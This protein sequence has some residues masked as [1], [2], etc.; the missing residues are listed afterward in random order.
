MRRA[1]RLILAGL[2]VGLG[3]CLADPV[4][5]PM[6]LNTPL[7]SYSTPA[8]SR[9]SGT[10]IAPVENGG[11]V[12]LPAGTV[13]H[14]TVRR[15]AKVGVGLV[16]DRATLELDFDTY[17]LPE[18]GR[19]PLRARLLSVDN[20]RETVAPDGRIRGVLATA[21]PQNFVQGVW[22]RPGDDFFTNTLLGLT[23]ASGKVA[24][25]YSLGP[26]G[27]A[28]LIAT[29]LA[30]FRMAE[31]EIRLPRGTEMHL[32]LMGI[33]DNAPVEEAQAPAAAPDTLA[34]WVRSQPL[35]IRRQ[36]GEAAEDMV[37]VIFA[38]SREQLVAAFEAAGWSQADRFDRQSVL[39]AYQA[40]TRQSGYATA[41]VSKLFYRGTEPEIVFQKSLNTISKRH[42]IRLWPADFEGERVWLGAA[43][44]DTGITLNRRKMTFTHRIDLELDAERKK[45]VDDISFAG[46]SAWSALVDREN[47]IREGNRPKTVLS[48]GRAAFVELRDCAYSN[49]T[50]ACLPPPPGNRLERTFRRGMLEARHHFIRASAYYWGFRAVT[51]RKPKDQSFPE[52]VYFRPPHAALE[53]VAALNTP[54]TQAGR[55]ARWR[56]RRNG[57]TS[58]SDLR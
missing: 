4:R 54:P 17:E 35:D 46:C 30:L 22:F 6:R 8:G 34:E 12:L 13:I 18:G 27:A 47:G 23:G 55:S 1:T 48:D 3:F 21:G 29:R 39:R 40:Y 37:N 24:A 38:G 53:E 2:T 25:E 56:L 45:V 42:H 26:I 7:T 36:N 32:L 50:L 41:P 49:T 51:Y 5:I 10:V 28:A 31:P 44:Q 16:R 14:G 43:T 52:M 15:A 19:Y 9:F 33:P 11:R 57:T 58:A 20:A